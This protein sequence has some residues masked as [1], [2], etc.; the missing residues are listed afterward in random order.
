MTECYGSSTSPQGRFTDFGATNDFDY[1]VAGDQFVPF[2]N[3]YNYGAKNYFQRPDKRYTLG[4]FAHYDVNEHVEAYTELM[5]MNDRSVSQVA[6]SGTFF[7]TDTLPCSNAFM[8]DQQF[9]TICGQYGLT[10]EDD[11]TVYV[12]RR[13]VEGGNRQ[14]D[15][16]TTRSAVCLACAGR[17]TIPGATTATTCIPR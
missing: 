1:E 14:D 7:N 10:A 2:E 12:G 17:S 11:Q 4:S 13:N 5:Y 9:E 6:P 3:L 8:S 16:G 15:L